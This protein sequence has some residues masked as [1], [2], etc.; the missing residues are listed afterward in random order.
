MT[1][2]TERETFNA[3]QQ[4][5]HDHMARTGETYADIAARAK[6]PRQTVSA[7]MNRDDFVGIP[8]ARTLRR[9]AKGLEVSEATVREAAAASI[10]TGDGHTKATPTAQVLADLVDALPDW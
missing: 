1:A 7:L 10:S 3:L 8:Q 5:I 6:C 4:L 2:R 9:L